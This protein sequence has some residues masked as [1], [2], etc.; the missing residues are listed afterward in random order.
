[1]RQDVDEAAGVGVEAVG[2]GD[3]AVEARAVELGDDED[4]VDAGLEAVADRDVDEPELAAHRHRRLRPVARQRPEPRPLT[5]TENGCDDLFHAASPRE[6]AL[7]YSVFGPPL[8]DQFVRE[9]DLGRD[10]AE[11]VV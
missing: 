5:P 3:V 9:T 7:S 1:G 11:A 6:A 8:G 2:L 10:M 4:T